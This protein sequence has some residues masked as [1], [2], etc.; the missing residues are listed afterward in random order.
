MEASVMQGGVERTVGL[1]L[2][3]LAVWVLWGEIGGAALRLPAVPDL[4][5][6]EAPQL[7][8]P[9]EVPLDPPPLLRKGARFEPHWKRNPFAA[10]DPWS[11][12][13]PDPIALPPAPAPEHLVPDVVTNEDGTLLAPRPAVLRRAAEERS[14]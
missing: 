2:A 11:D 9:E 5:P 12:P 13:V 4:P 3:A 14:P 10:P 6:T 8:A 7:L 1:V